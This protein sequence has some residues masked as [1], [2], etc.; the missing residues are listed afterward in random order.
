MCGSG[1]SYD[2]LDAKWR[3]TREGHRGCQDSGGGV[4]RCMAGKAKGEGSGGE[5][6]MWRIIAERGGV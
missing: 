1:W 4:F 5:G 2:R 3:A 6:G